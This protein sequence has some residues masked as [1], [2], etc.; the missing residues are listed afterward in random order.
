MATKHQYRLYSITAGGYLSALQVGIQSLHAAAELSVQLDSPKSQSVYKAW[1]QED[2]TAIIL[3][4]FN[5]AGVL[6][7]Y[8]QISPL[9]AK[10]GLPC[11]L[12]RE[13]EAS[14]NGAATAMS[15][16]LPVELY[17]AKLI[18]ENPEVECSIPTFVYTAED[19]SARIYANTAPHFKLIEAIRSYPLYR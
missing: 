8:E 17:A 18:P 15:V 7:A 10:L 2:K 12:F 9:A 4:A 14:L 3:T 19:G 5:H 11:A 6:Q 1:A 13:D 16:I